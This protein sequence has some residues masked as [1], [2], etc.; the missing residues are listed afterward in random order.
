MK[1]LLAFGLWIFVK[2][3]EACNEDRDGD[4]IS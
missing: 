4:K 2:S 1:S 3:I